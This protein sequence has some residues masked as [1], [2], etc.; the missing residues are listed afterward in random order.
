[1]IIWQHNGGSIEKNVSI[2]FF[3]IITGFILSPGSRNPVDFV[4]DDDL[5]EFNIVEYISDNQLILDNVTE[6]TNP[7][8]AYVFR[9][10][11]DI[12]GTKDPDDK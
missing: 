8:A 6:I 5:L 12:F 1:M 11:V 7:D 9:S 2:L 3:I 4:F 10:P